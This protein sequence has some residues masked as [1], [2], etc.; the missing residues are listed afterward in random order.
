MNI[1][2]KYLHPQTLFPMECA[3]NTVNSQLNHFHGGDYIVP[4]TEKKET[5]L[6]KGLGIM[7]QFLYSFFST[8]KVNEMN[9]CM[10]AD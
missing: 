10:V 7:Q 3:F 4:R 9:E 2:K 8:I 1:Q 5:Q 6:I